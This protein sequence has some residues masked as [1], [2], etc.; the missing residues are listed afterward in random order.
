MNALIRRPSAGTI[1]LS[2]TLVVLVAKILL[3]V[4]VS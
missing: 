2:A 3:A 4:A 1:V